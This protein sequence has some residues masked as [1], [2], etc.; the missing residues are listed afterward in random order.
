MNATIDANTLHRTAKYFMDNGRA[1]THDEA[2]DI[3][4]RFGLTVHVGPE[5]ANSIH[6]QTALLTLVNAA[7]RTLLGGVEIVGLPNVAC[8]SPLAPGGCLEKAVQ[9]VG[10]RIVVSP[11]PEW[12][13][14]MIGD[15]D[16]DLSKLP[17][18]RLTWDGWRGG[19]VPLRD[20]R[21]LADR[22]AIALAPVLAAAA[23]AAE[24]FAYHAG[25]HPMAG[26]R[27]SGLSLW[28]PG[29]NWLLGDETE[30]LLAFLPSRLW[31]IGLGN[32]GQAFAWALAT[33]PYSDRSQV[34]LV[35]Q[36][37]DRTAGSN[38]STSLL[39]SA[40]DINRR[41]ARIVAEWLDCRGFET[42]VNEL[43][44]GAWTR[45][46]EDE[47]SVALCGVDNALAR[48]ALEKPGF[49]LIVE[50][51]LGAGPE[52]FRSI[53]V[54]TFPSSRSAKEIWSRQVGQ[55]TDNVES[56]PAYQA[57]KRNGMD[58]C[59]LAQLA[60]R[61]VG[62]PFV[63]LVAA[64]LVLSELLRRLH[65]GGALE[66]AAGSVAALDDFEAVPISC[67]PYSY[68]HLPVEKGKQI[69][70][71]YGHDGDRSAG[72]QNGVIAEDVEHLMR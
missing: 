16:V 44:F 36:D 70:R 29:E 13:S 68:G 24:V 20:E 53:S 10:G 48:A 47:P 4:S 15:A 23:C 61:T 55:A 57:L 42:Y 43:R 34:E 65:G 58:T 45:R 72:S 38:E 31:I 54:H 51:G 30:P 7:R 39:S 52:A 49:G 71:P 14:A 63:G 12:P 56:M 62:V 46:A 1:Q 33:L 27:S 64:C 9:D 18:W 35:L 3:L 2:M 6:H 25:D 66:L 8:C 40:S 19:V 50:A 21:H 67:G 11:N 69:D 32:L 22:E 59:G 37:F 5:V 26:R 60:S 28:R 17:C 41:K